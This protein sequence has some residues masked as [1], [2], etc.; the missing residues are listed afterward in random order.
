MVFFEE[1]NFNIL[2]IL[3]F[4]KKI[5][6][7]DSSSIIPLSPMESTST[8]SP[9][10]IKGEKKLK[11]FSF[12]ST[13]KLAKKT[14][15]VHRRSHSID[16]ISTVKGNNVI[17]NKMNNGNDSED[18]FDTEVWAWGKGKRGQQGQGDML[19]RLQPLQISTL[20]GI[21]V[22]KICSGDKHSLAI[23]ITGLIFGW[24]ENSKGQA[25]PHFSLAVCSVPQVSHFQIFK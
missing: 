7:I 20:S 13:P 5:I 6:V 23:T 24:G 10:R 2:C 16:K 18:V 12:N 3:G 17:D 4:L 21:G 19:D 14:L 15:L 9:L 11:N 25:C 8:T 1:H 22:V